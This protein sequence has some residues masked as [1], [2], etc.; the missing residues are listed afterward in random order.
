ME[1]IE[2]MKRHE[3]SVKKSKRNQK[4]VRHLEVI[5]GGFKF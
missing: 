2:M 1:E 4:G 3:H 5:S